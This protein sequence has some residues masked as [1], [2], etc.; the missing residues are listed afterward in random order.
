[1]VL[2]KRKSGTLRWERNWNGNSWDIGTL[3]ET[4]ESA[5]HDGYRGKERDYD[6][7]YSTAN[8]TDIVLYDARNAIITC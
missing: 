8:A 6:A 1:M 2:L 5:D 3:H 4:I 7:E